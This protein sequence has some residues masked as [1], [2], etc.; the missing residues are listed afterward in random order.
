MTGG[1][2]IGS[3]VVCGRGILVDGGSTVVVLMEVVM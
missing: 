1:G 2:T 3:G